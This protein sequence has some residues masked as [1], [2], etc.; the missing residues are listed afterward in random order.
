MLG[1][2]SLVGSGG[3][4]AEVLRGLVAGSVRPHCSS[5][6]QPRCARLPCSPASSR[7]LFPNLTPPLAPLDQFY[8]SG[9]PW[10]K[11]CADSV[12]GWYS[13][14]RV[15]PGK[16]FRLKHSE[17]QPSRFQQHISIFWPIMMKSENWEV[18]WYI[19]GSCRFVSMPRC[20]VG[21]SR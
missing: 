5:G 1:D 20:S 12:R 17:N 21:C 18:A 11:T 16:T 19:T 4:L 10:V 13:K 7:H 6:P 9:I 14:P 8:P 2:A 3:L 15:Q